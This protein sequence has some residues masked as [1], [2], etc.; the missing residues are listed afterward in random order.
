MLEVVSSLA[1][2]GVAGWPLGLTLAAL[3]AGGR[4]REAR[5][6]ESLN[7]ALH[8]LRRPVT[9][10]VLE[11]GAGKGPGSH[12]IRVTLAALD[13]LDREING[14]RLRP[15]PR[16]VALRALLEP[17]VERWRG[18]AAASSRSLVLTWRAGS[19][20][21]MA[22][23]ARIA[24][25]LDNLID[26]ALRH[27]GLR[28]TVDASICPRGARIAV[29]DSGRWAGRNRGSPD[30]RHGH[31]LKVVGDVAREHGGRFAVQGSPAGTRAVLE[32]PLAPAAIP[33]AEAA[34][35]A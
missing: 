8:E 19:A 31:G 5:R 7:R 18:I 14:D 10:L 3:A 17:A 12:A 34:L 33:A 11:P 9:S 27:G 26:N 1:E 21:V 15:S 30:P 20:M 4:L 13:D 22:D 35:A 2:A 23:P 25:A 28:V 16:P 32:L 6:R 29:A 24:R